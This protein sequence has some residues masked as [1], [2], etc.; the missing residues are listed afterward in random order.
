[1]EIENSIRMKT[2]YGD[3]NLYEIEPYDDEI[4]ASHATASAAPDADASSIRSCEE[5]ID[6]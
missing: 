6:I 1:V 3:Q 4:I 2:E 5:N